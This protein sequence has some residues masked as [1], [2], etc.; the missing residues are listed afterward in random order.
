MRYDGRAET[1]K[2]K[3]QRRREEDRKR[4]G[5]QF[6]FNDILSEPSDPPQYLEERRAKHIRML[7]EI[8]DRWPD[9]YLKARIC[10]D[11]LKL[12][13]LGSRKVDL[14]QRQ[15]LE[16]PDL[17]HLSVEELDRIIQAGKEPQGDGGAGGRGAR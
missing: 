7:E 12:S 3:R 17:S 6:T 9:P 5:L 10:V 2:A 4:L 8:A 14:T 11:L 16:L 1:L 15:S 13:S